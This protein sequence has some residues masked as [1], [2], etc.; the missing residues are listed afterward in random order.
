MNFLNQLA[1]NLAEH[2]SVLVGMAIGWAGGIV[3]A[4]YSHRLQTVAEKS[5]ERKSKL[6]A[7]VA[8]CYE[9]NAWGNRQEEFC[10]YGAARPSESSPIAKIK[11][12]VFLYFS[13][14]IDRNLVRDLSVGMGE[15]YKCLL[16]SGKQKSDGNRE[17][18]AEHLCL[19]MNQYEKTLKLRDDLVE[20]AC[21]VMEKELHGKLSAGERI[22][23]AFNKYCRN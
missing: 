19:S 6:E 14:E 18:Y 12:I 8:E 10:L 4:R 3:T 23:N 16:E 17:A 22:R 7:L 21:N 20:A 9:I 2:F 5:K 15:Y 11:A 1:A 13:K